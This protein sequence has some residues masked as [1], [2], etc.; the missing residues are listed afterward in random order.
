MANGSYTGPLTVIRVQRP[1]LKPLLCPLILMRNEEYLI[2]QPASLRRVI[3]RL[4]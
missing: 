2:D 4:T 3:T 1:K